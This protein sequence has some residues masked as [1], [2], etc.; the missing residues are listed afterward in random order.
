M[1]ASAGAQ[2]Q[3]S[4]TSVSTVTCGVHVLILQSVVSASEVGNVPSSPAL[5]VTLA[6][7]RNKVCKTATIR[8]STPTWN[9]PI[10]LFVHL[11][12]SDRV[13]D[14]TRACRIAGLSSVLTF[15]LKSFRGRLVSPSVVGSVNITSADLLN[16]RN[17]E[18]RESVVTA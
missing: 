13:V 14:H 7:S 10:Q 1:A 11:R 16:R 17:E 5:Y 15:R 3:Y 12:W 4:L 9:H 2:R 18:Q 6:L 8:S